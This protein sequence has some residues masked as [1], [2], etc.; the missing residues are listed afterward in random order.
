MEGTEVG[1]VR[2]VVTTVRVRICVCK[3]LYLASSLP[4]RCQ[5]SDLAVLCFDQARCGDSSSPQERAMLK[6]SWCLDTNV[7]PERRIRNLI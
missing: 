4:Q 3:L 6:G 2:A 1:K 5:T 7:D